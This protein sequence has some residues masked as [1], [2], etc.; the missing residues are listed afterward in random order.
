MSNHGRSAFLKSTTKMPPMDNVN[1]IRVGFFAPDFTLKDSESKRIGL[2]DFFGKKNVVLFFYKGKKCKFCLDW[3]GEL[4]NAYDRIR[5]KNAEIVGISLDEIWV[6]QKLKRKK[7]IEFPIL[8]NDR[9]TKGGPVAPK[10]SEQYGVQMS[11]SERPDL[12]PAVF[13]IDKR[14]I[15]RFKKVCTHPTK[16]P[17]IDE[18]LCELDK[19]S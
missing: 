17:T 4:A 2:S 12:H 9:D 18:L 3:A 13:I 6:S 1:R 16:K 14:G 8:K 7:K 19:L 10:V 11:K 5:L 15:I